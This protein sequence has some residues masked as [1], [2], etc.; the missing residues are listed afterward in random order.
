MLHSSSIEISRSALSKNLRFLRKYIGKETEICSVVKGNAYGHG[1]D[2][3][4]PLAEEL[5][6]RWFAVFSAD[7]ALVALHARGEQSE[8]MIMGAVDADQ[9]PWVIENRI[10]F[11]IFGLRRL[12]AAIETAKELNMPA[13]IHLE[14]ETGLNRMG[15]FDE[16]LEEAVELIK[17]N[18]ESVEVVGVCTHLAGAESVSNYV[19]IQKQIEIFNETTAW[20]K[21][22]GV[23]YQIRHTASSA[24]TFT[25]PETRMEMV[26]VGIAQFGFWPSRETKMHYFLQQGEDSKKKMRDPLKR[27]VSWKSR[28]MNVKEV[29]PGEF[30]SYGTSYMTTRRQRIASVPVGYYHGFVRGLSNL[31]H[32]LVRGRRAQ[33]VGKVNMNMM[34]ID[35]TD[36]GG[37]EVGDEVVIIGKQGKQEIS[38][39]AFSDIARVLNYEA[40]VRIPTEIPRTVVD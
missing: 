29:P 4:V 16:N 20:L 32:V 12:R 11:Y 10:S 35:T 2:V 5:G 21:M 26:R 28:V 37:V 7:E 9:L 34:M 31:G 30:V 25:Y 40:L 6:I 8:I 38:V 22:Q 24:A 14:L 39:A 17:Q 3:F 1:I 18:H 19:R 27:V 33:V 15:L 36:I 13:R 23:D